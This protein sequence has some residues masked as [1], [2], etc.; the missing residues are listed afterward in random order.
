VGAAML[1]LRADASEWPIVAQVFISYERSAEAEARR[2]GELLRKHG[3]QTW[4]D[5][6]IPPHR[7]YGDVIQERLHAADVVL[8]LWSDGAAN[9]H[10]VRAEADYALA[11]HKLVQA[12][13]DTTALPLPFNRIQYARL[14]DWGADAAHAEWRKVLGSIGQVANESST[15]SD[16]AATNAAAGST[17]GAAGVAASQPPRRLG[18]RGLTVLLIFGVAVAAAA[19]WFL[20]EGPRGAAPQAVARIA[21]L[22]FDVL[23]AD[24]DTRFFA[25]GLT[26]LLAT[27]LARNHIQVV[28]RDDAATLRGT[29]RDAAVQRLGIALLLDGTVQRGK[30]TITVRTHLDDPV[31]HALVWSSEETG[32]AAD[33]ARLQGRVASTVVGMLAC[34][35][36][37][38]RPQ[39]GLSDPA[40]LARYLRACDIFAN[41]NDSTAHPEESIEMLAALREVTV[42]APQFVA[43]HTDLAKFDGYLAPRW[44][45]EQAAKMRQEAAEEAQRALALD[46]KAPDAYLAQYFLQPID[47]YAERERLL[48][49]G[50]AA[51][52]MWPHTNGFLAQL[53]AGVGRI[54]EATVFGQ[55][56]AAADL[57]IDWSYIGVWLV[58]SNGGPTAPCIETLSR[59]LAVRP[60]GVA[61][62]W[63]LVGCYANAERWDA[64]RAM[65]ADAAAPIAG[66]RTQAAGIAYFDA[67]QTGTPDAR[68]RAR[69]ALLDS[70]AE[71]RQIVINDLA[72]LGYIDDAF[73]VAEGF[74]PNRMGDPGL[75]FVKTTRA[76]RRDP[77]FMQLAARIGLVEYWRTS[78]HWPDFC[79]DADL[80]YDCRAEADRIAAHDDGG[81]ANRSTARD[82]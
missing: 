68:E 15:T 9:S 28:S 63:A 35:N 49:L 70:V 59:R 36:R 2:V 34:S 8:V 3:H 20:R 32:P 79:S 30:D 21:I 18:R 12:S 48:R 57:Q 67:M 73:A 53:L 46:P 25:N 19:A 1:R 14:Q 10:W 31:R 41:E 7:D 29:D 71:T 42:K 81:H 55:V 40:L 82:G 24:A 52:P 39:N 13:L 75:L 33:V 6:E 62:W 11:H 77:R 78:G 54:D 50:V 65:V 60:E 16:A 58:A 26:D 61:D 80:P 5:E 66:S 51:D 69:K 4:S 44:P 76:M 22:P 72:S 37:A 74:D 27:T 45:P 64:A 43:A 17:R 56:A 23:S 47:H 38:L